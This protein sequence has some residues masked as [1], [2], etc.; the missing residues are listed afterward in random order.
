MPVR[1]RPEDILWFEEAMTVDVSEEGL[2]FLSNREY[3][4]GEHLF[5]SFEPSSPAPWPKELRSRVVRVDGVAQSAALA[6]SV[7]RFP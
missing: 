4:T 5:I 2:R 1:V 3:R 7:R 6:V